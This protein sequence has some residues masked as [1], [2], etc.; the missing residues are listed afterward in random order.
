[1]NNTY[2]ISNILQQ[3]GKLKN[4]D[5]CRYETAGETGRPNL[6]RTQLH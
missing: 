4:L 1:L 2:D 5:K 3:E 6:P